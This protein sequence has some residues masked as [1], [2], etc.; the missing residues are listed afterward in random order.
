MIAEN[1]MTAETSPD[2]RAVVAHLALTVVEEKLAASVCPACG[3]ELSGTTPP[4][5]LWCDR[6]DAIWL[7]GLPLN[8]QARSA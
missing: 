8:E 5:A 7:F 4:V 1:T 3:A 6:C 2:K